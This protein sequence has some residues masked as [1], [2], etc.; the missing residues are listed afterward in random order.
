MPK[1]LERVNAMVMACESHDAWAAN[2]EWG[3]WHTSAAHFV[4]E[5]LPGISPGRLVGWSVASTRRKRGRNSA[6]RRAAFPWLPR[7]RS[8]IPRQRMIWPQRRRQRRNQRRTRTGKE[9]GR[10][11]E[12]LTDKRTRALRNWGTLRKASCEHSFPRARGKEREQRASKGCVACER[13]MGDLAM[14]R[15]ASRMT[16]ISSWRPRGGKGWDGGR[17]VEKG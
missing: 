17:F 13:A 15:M 10:R 12:P 7:S 14:V 8:S 11:T 6:Q 5:A 16:S 1:R 2:S 3:D 9:T 4:L